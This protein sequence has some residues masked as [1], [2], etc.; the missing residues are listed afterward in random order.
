M[1][2]ILKSFSQ[3]LSMDEIDRHKK[4]NGRTKKRALD[5]FRRL[6][7]VLHGQCEELLIREAGP[8]VKLVLSALLLPSERLSEALDFQRTDDRLVALVAGLV[9][10]GRNALLLTHD[11]GP[12]ATAKTLN[13]PF[14]LIP[15]EWLRP[16]KRVKRQSELGNLSRSSVATHRKNLI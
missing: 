11:A 10:G 2:T 7:P 16:P 9:D 4:G 3:N 5:T 12:A 14:F 15:D 1:W 6:R 13:V 8:T